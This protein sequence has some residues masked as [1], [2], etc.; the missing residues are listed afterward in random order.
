MDCTTRF[1]ELL[2]AAVEYEAEAFDADEGEDASV[3][4]GDLVEWFAQW[5]ENVKDALRDQKRER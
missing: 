2:Q 1:Q 4:G 5:R 3:N